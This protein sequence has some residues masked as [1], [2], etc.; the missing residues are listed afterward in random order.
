MHSCLHVTF[1]Y[2]MKEL[3]TIRN[4]YVYVSKGAGS[5]TTLTFR[6]W[7]EQY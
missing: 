5:T 4:R 1:V 7:G 2:V 3:K 6:N